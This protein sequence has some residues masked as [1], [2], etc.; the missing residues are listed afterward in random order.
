MTYIPKRVLERITRSVPK[1]QKVLQVA[2]DRDVNES[3]TV[4]IVQDI[5]G[6]VFGY[7]KYLEVTSEY[8][9]R[10]TYCDLAIKVDN[11]VQFLIEVKAIGIELKETHLRQVIEYGANHGISWV[12]LTNGDDWRLHKIRFEKPIDH[13]LVTGFRF[14]ELNPRAERDREIL[15]LLTKEGLAKNVREEFFERVQNVNKFVI[16]RLILADPVLSVIRRELRKFSDGVRVDKAE[17]EELIKS[18]VLKRELV[19]SEDAKEAKARVDR[20]YRKGT[21]RR[22]RRVSREGESVEKEDGRGSS[23]DRSLEDSEGE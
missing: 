10:G 8:A 7:D 6:E 5:M 9:V 17:I 2:K 23:S 15:F 16:A 1:F 13:D 3:D 21:R 18:E 19:D 12:V 22:R 14:S 20:F 4:A 11:K